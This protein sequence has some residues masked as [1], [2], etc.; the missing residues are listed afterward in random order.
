MYNQI[1]L[2]GMYVLIAFEGSV[3]EEASINTKV[4]LNEGDRRL[5]LSQPWPVGEGASFSDEGSI[6]R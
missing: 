2:I 6:K 3:D 5:L 4:G 1:T